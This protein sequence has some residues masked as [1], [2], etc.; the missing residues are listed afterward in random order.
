MKRVVITGMGAVTP[1]GN[2]IDVFW[3]NIKNGVIGIDFIKK[4]DISDFKVKVA[5]EV[6]D[7]DPS[8]YI[9]NKEKK[10]LDLF[11]QYAIYSSC[12]AFYDAGLTEEDVKDNYR[13][14]VIFGSGIGGL[15]TIEEQTGK[16]HL[17]SHERISPLFI[18]MAITNMAAGNISIKLGINGFSVATVTA[19]AT[20]NNCI[21]DAFRQIK[22]GYSDVILCGGSEAAISRLGI[23]SFNA[24]TALSRSDEPQRASIPFDKD[25]N[26]FVMGEGSGTLVLEELEH[27]RKRGAKIYG[28][29]VGYGCTSDAYHITSPNPEGT[30]AAM[31]IKLA[32]EEANISTS[33]IDY[34][35]AHGT[36]TDYNDIGET[37]AIKKIFGDIAYDI[38]VSST[39]SMIGHLLGAAGAAEAIICVKAL[40]DG[41]V[42]PTVNLLEPDEEC[43]LNYVA[44][45]GME[46]KLNYVLSNSFGFGGHNAVLCFK[47]WEE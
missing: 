43:D 13:V 5:A 4:F 3:N 24:L 6:K 30:G 36:S 15:S 2:D 38:P 11:C 42:P 47:K 40:N 22:H 45:K 14:G 18:P 28:E 35:N 39:K 17:K 19:C 34:I 10:R 12:K 7:F 8:E 23:A 1:V 27:A 26:G 32:L 29:V 33:Q 20:S 41:F 21:G 46:K 25:R 37:R 44:N 31:A 9:N 16:M